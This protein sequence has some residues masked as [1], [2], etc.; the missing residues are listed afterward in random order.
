MVAWMRGK[1]RPEERNPAAM[2]SRRIYAPVLNL[3][4]RRPK[5]T[6]LL[7]FLLVPAVLSARAVA[8][9]GVH[10]AAAG[11]IADVHADGA[12]DDVCGAGAGG[13][14]QDRR[15]HHGRFPE[16]RSVLGKAGKAESST[17]P[18]PV[19]MFETTIV[20][21]PREAVAEGLPPRAGTRADRTG[22]SRSS[23]RSGP[24]GASRHRRS[25]SPR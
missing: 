20:L 11:G 22:S 24:R 1:I 23:V 4:L 21:K 8:R 17:D 3:A 5:T 2:L 12:S 15:D 9:I 25:S 16:V 19:E 13:P 14:R 18:A 10:A 6:L 7:N